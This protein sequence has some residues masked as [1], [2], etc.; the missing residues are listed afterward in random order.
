MG[1]SYM[2]DLAIKLT[3]RAFEW[4]AA[5]KQAANQELLE[6][7]VRYKDKV[8]LRGAYLNQGFRAD[9]DML[10][11]MYGHEFE[12]IQDLQLEFRQTKF[13]RAV[14]TPWA[15]IGMSM[16]SE[17]NKSHLPSF[18]RGIPAKKYL[19]FYPFIRTSEW[20]LLPA[21]ERSTMLK[22]HGNFG[23][24]FEG[25]LTNGVYAFGLGDFEWLL[26]FETDNLAVLSPMVRRLREA[27]ARLYT[28]YEW[29]FIVGRHFTLDE[30]L[31]RL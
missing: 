24:E 22:E 12:D 4:T 27:K 23:R 13:G 19:C 5:E 9:T 3:P 11:W 16:D 30:A 17:F 18:V 28:K 14:E 6:L 1:A 2:S 21:E 29:H 10:F 26:S 31:K 25:I 7:F 8:T 20:Y 15:F